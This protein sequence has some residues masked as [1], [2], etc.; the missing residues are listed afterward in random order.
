[1][2]GPHLLL[3]SDLLSVM[4]RRLAFAMVAEYLAIRELPFEYTRGSSQD[5]ALAGSRG[6]RQPTYFS[7]D[8]SNRCW[9]STSFI[10]RAFVAVE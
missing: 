1:M 7:R 2:T 4:P 10:G 5:C 9:K 6:L 8:M 3:I